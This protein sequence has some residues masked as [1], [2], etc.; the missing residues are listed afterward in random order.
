ML[1]K[2]INIVFHTVTFSY[3]KQV[4]RVAYAKEYETGNVTH[5]Y[6]SL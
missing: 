4:F 5:I 2:Y 1:K 6:Y 3:T